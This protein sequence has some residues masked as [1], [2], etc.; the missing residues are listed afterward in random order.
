MGRGA[1]VVANCPLT[2]SYR[3]TNAFLVVNI[4]ST[5]VRAPEFKTNAR[6]LHIAFFAG[7]QFL[8]H[9]IMLVPDRMIL[10]RPEYAV[11]ELFVKRSRLK[12]EGVKVCIG[13]TALN[14]IG[15][16]TLHQFLAKA[17][18]PHRRG[19]SK[20]FNVQPSR[21]NMSDQSTQYLTVFVPEKESDRIPFRLSGAR[22]AI[23]IDNRLYDVALPGGIGIEHYGGVAHN[24]K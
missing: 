11:P 4:T 3:Q 13:A 14:R 6:L 19:Y 9:E 23:V 18:P 22:N 10:K 21:P 24:N 8:S 20:G 17:T 15:L 12:T 7:I 5:G 16:G 1:S 2:F